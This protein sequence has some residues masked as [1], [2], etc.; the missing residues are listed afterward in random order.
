APP[1]AALFPYPTLFRSEGVDEGGL[2]G[3][4]LA[5]HC[6]QERAVDE[7]DQARRLRREVGQLRRG[8]EQAVRG[9]QEAVQVGGRLA[10]AGAVHL[11]RKRTRLNSL[12]SPPP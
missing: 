9:A 7:V 11:D 6:H 2:A 3:V 10:A 4:E 12:P 8:G 5:H 1:S